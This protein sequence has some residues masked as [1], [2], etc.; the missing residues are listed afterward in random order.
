MIVRRKQPAPPT[1]TVSV[2]MTKEEVR[3]AV[4]QAMRHEVVGLD[5]ETTGCDPRKESP[6]YKATAFSFQIS[7][8]SHAVFIPTFRIEGVCD[9]T[10]LIE[11]LIPLVEGEEPK[12]VLHNAKY[13]MHVAA[14]AG[15][16]PNPKALRGDTLVMSYTYNNSF[17]RHGLKEC[18]KRWFHK[19]TNEYK[20]TFEVPKINKNGKPGKLTI[21][22]NL[23]A[24]ATSDYSEWYEPRVKEF[25]TK[26]QGQQEGA[27]RLCE[28]HP[29]LDPMGMELL[30]AY[31][32]LDPLYTAMLYE[33]L[34]EKMKA[35]KWYGEKNLFQYFELIEVP[36]TM[37]LYAMERRGAPISKKKVLEAKEKC[38]ADIAATLTEFNRLAVKAGASVERMEK[39][40]TGSG[41]DIA[42]LFTEVLGVAGVQKRRKNGTTSESW[43]AESL[44]KIKGKGK[45]LAE[46]LLKYRN[47]AKILSGYIEPFLIMYDEYKGRLH[48]TY[49]QTGTATGRLSSAAPNLQVAPKVGKKDPYTIR[50]M[51][52]GDEFDLSI[53]IGDIDLAQVEARITADITLDELL[54]KS[55]RLGW[56]MHSL[57]ALNTFDEVRAFAGTRSVDAALLAEIKEKFPEQRNKAKIIF[58]A[59]LYGQ[60]PMGYASQT[61]SSE[62][63][64]V[65]AIANFFN[66]YPGIKAS[67]RKTVAFA[68]EKGYIRTALRRYVYV[69]SIQSSINKVRM[70]GERQCFN[71]RIQGSASD[72][73]RL[74]MI[75]IEHDPYIRSLGVQMRLQVHDE[76][77]F[78]G[79]KEA[80]D[81]AKE[82]IEYYVSHPFEAWGFKPMC[83]D[84]P[85][86][87]DTGSS[88]A[89]A[90]K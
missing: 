55:I 72:M 86:E 29:E 54:L 16:V 35:K 56:D 6:V 5:S 85:G 87:M 45:A 33:L 84:T 14:N 13:D 2:A 30:I 41:K 67:M 63:Q 39:F 74:T 48:T 77:I 7:W 47:A 61:G 21:L 28:A 73:M 34:R 20:E 17:D 62:Q 69:P 44:K 80:L 46:C 82:K 57:T 10:D 1:F 88:W 19:D 27:E 12:L 40:N 24:V 4:K 37:V 51:F 60:G 32:S 89:E 26:I 15:L 31:A 52:V 75:K 3:L 8:G 43:D 38:E 71:Y 83:V 42:W 49:K 64:G 18:I 11:E 65:T 50:A 76:L 79:T 66:G 58:F 78:T 70:E 36:Y 53:I 81:A 68:R 25:R 59:I 23:Y 90:K 9:F 22:P